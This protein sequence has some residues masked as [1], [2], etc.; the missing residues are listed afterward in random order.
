[1]RE[2]HTKT[3]QVKQPNGYYWTKYPLI[4][5]HN[6]TIAQCQTDRMGHRIR[7]GTRK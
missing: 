2:K 3:L 4:I 6:R 1:M 5:K 7:A